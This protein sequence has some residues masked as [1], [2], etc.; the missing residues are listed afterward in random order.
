MLEV[1]IKG[2]RDGESERERERI[3]QSIPNFCAFTNDI[4]WVRE[5]LA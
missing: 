3:S 2:G 5:K 4:F 1:E